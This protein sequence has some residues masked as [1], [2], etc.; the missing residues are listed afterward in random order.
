MPMTIYFRG[1]STRQTWCDNNGPLSIKKCTKF[2]F[3]CSTV[4][5][6]TVFGVDSGRIKNF[7]TYALCG[8]I[9]RHLQCVD[10][11]RH[12]LGIK[13]FIF[14]I[15]ESIAPASAIHL[16]L[17]YIYMNVVGFHWRGEKWQRKKESNISKKIQ[18]RDL[19]AKWL[20][21]HSC[22]QV[23]YVKARAL[24]AIGLNCAYAISH[25]KTIW[26]H[27]RIEIDVWWSL[28]GI[29]FYTTQIYCMRN[30]TIELCSFT[31]NTPIERRIISTANSFS[32]LLRRHFYMRDTKRHLLGLDG[33]RTPQWCKILSP[34]LISTETLHSIEL[35]SPGCD[36]F[37]RMCEIPQVLLVHIPQGF[38]FHF[39]LSLLEAER[40]WMYA[41]KTHVSRA[42]FECCSIRHR[43]THM[44]HGHNRS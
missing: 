10:Q 23:K 7:Y 44:D 26:F 36:N 11:N 16:C 2:Y 29:N 28:A 3:R 38:F 43:H 31:W 19:H 25:A 15:M 27:I 35:L 41:W 14:M 33:I 4:F 1:V 37:S 22:E 24:S 42:H 17:N 21:S 34:P 13:F 8:R 6:L 32:F 20:Q 39:L 18:S 12:V 30:K 5:I 9:H 40:Y